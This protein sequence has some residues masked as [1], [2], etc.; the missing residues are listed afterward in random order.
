VKTATE[1]VP[2]IPIG[3]GSLLYLFVQRIIPAANRLEHAR[4]EFDAAVKQHRSR[5]HAGSVDLRRRVIAHEINRDQQRTTIWP[6]EPSTL[7][8][9]MLR[10]AS[11]RSPYARSV[12]AQAIV[13]DSLVVGRGIVAAVRCPFEFR[14]HTGARYAIRSVRF[15]GVTDPP[16]GVVVRETV[17]LMPGAAFVATKRDG[18]TEMLQGISPS[19]AASVLR[20]LPDIVA[21]LDEELTRVAREYGDA[22]RQLE[23][24]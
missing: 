8:P 4:R 9:A 12:D 18:S 6:G 16:H 1:G 5:L 3:E 11:A 14:L 13:N 21:T 24:L 10:L 7:G 22:I 23:S 20:E 2:V 17:A 15:P 19:C